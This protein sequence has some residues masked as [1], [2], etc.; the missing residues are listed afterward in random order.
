[1]LEGRRDFR[2]RRHTGILYIVLMRCTN[3]G[4]R[5]PHDAGACPE[6]GV[7]ARVAPAARQRSLTLLLSL[8]L[9]ALTVAAAAYFLTRG[10][11]AVRSGRQRPIRVVRDRPGGARRGDGATISEPEAILRLQRS[12]DAAPECIAIMSKGYINGGYI[13]EA[14][15]RC[16]GTRSGRWRVDGGSGAMRPSDRGVAPPT[17]QH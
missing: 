3:C 6:C 13:L 17:G 11:H 2:G 14:I 9:I 1:M 8:L 12:F 4:A 10:S 16:D 7:F 5:V 15:N